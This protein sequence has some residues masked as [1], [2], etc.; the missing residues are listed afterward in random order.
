MKTVCAPGPRTSPAHAVVDALGIGEQDEL[1]PTDAKSRIVCAGDFTQAQADRLEGPVT[2]L[3]SILV[4][5]GLEAVEIEI[6]QGGKFPGALRGRKQ[7]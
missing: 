4:V 5:D 6:E 1:V 2:G 7:A 3:V